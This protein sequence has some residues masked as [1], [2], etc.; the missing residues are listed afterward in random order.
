MK[1]TLLKSLTGRLA[2]SALLALAASGTMATP[3]AI[4]TT[5]AANGITDLYSASFEV[6]QPCTGSSPPYCSFFGVEPPATRNIVFTPSPTGVINAVPL[7]F[8][9]TPASGSFL[10]LTLNSTNTQVTI[11]GG[12]IAFPSID[13]TIQSSSQFGA[14]V[15]ASGVGMVFNGAPQSAVVDT[16]G[17]AVFF[18]DLGPTI[19]VD[20]STFSTVAFPPNGSCTE[21]PRFDCRILP[22]LT[23]DMIRYRLFLD[24]DPTF[25]SFTGDFIGQ[26]GNNSLVY[27]TLNSV[28]P[29]PPTIWLLGTGLAGLGGRRWLRRK[30]AA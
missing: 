18:V 11:A 4:D 8:A 15:R 19:A 13:L 22:I 27:A 24:F 9:S 1:P 12:T 30:A 28:V 21:A 17:I 23:L 6:G 10:D 26:T 25:T 29:L 14:V 3:V 20:F 7:G 16:N 2:V 5:D